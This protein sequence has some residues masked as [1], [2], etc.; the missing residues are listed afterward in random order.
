MRSAWLPVGLVLLGAAGAPVACGEAFQSTAS[1]TSGS[2]GGATTGMG[3]AGGGSTSSTDSTTASTASSSSTGGTACTTVAQ[4]PGTSTLCGQ[5]TCNEGTC[6]FQVLQPDGPSLSQVYGDCHVVH[7]AKGQLVKKEE[8]N[9]TY[10]DGND[11]TSDVCANGSPS[12]T[13]N[14]GSQCDLNSHCSAAG[15]CVECLDSNDCVESA[16]PKCQGNRCVPTACTNGLPDIG[17]TDLDCGG[18]DCAP[19]DDVKLCDQTT[20]CVSAV[21]SVKP[22]EVLKTCHHDCADGV[23][24]GTETGP[25]CGGAVCGPRCSVGKGCLVP[26]DCKSSVCKEGLCQTATCTDGVKN[27]TELGVDCGPDCPQACPG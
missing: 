14:T 10:D 19:C 11:C 27:A 18:P 21:C 8:S 23:K 12:N 9:E 26:T 13:V 6:G 2:G 5:V 22:G 24:N 25:D 15:A 1:T 16:K 3:G 20:D 4:C 7:C 17:E